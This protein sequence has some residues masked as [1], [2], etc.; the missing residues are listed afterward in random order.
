[1]I[2]EKK[3]GFPLQ[4]TAP[5]Y[6]LRNIMTDSIPN[7]ACSKSLQS[8]SITYTVVCANK[9]HVQRFPQR[10]SR[11]EKATGV[12]SPYSSSRVFQIG[13]KRDQTTGI[14][15]YWKVQRNTHLDGSDPACIPCN[16]GHIIS[17]TGCKSSQRQRN[18]GLNFFG[19]DSV[20]LN[21]LT[22]Y[23]VQA[24]SLARIII[25]PRPY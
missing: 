1:M 8:L 4:T 5:H 19:E 15:P 14:T 9:T 11:H 6:I 7:H 3:V 16:Q 18:H 20:G 12:Y 23:P 17:N 24:V 25:S 22:K 21:C 10:P 2:S 13:N